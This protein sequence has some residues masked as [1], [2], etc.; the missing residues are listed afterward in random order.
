MLSLS[1]RITAARLP[2]IARST[3][4]NAGSRPLQQFAG[5]VNAWDLTVWVV[6]DQ[7]ADRV[8]HARF[9]PNGSSQSMTAIV[10]RL[11]ELGTVVDSLGY[12]TCQLHPIAELVW[13]LIDQRVPWK[14]VLVRHARHAMLPAAYD[15]DVRIGPVWKRG[16]VY[17]GGQPAP[18]SFKIT[19]D[20][21]RN[22]ISCPIE[23]EHTTDYVD[24]LRDEYRQWWHALEALRLECHANRDSLPGLAVRPLPYAAEP[25]SVDDGACKTKT[26]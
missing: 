17:H 6:R 23:P 10:A 9:T 7:R 25:W 22:A 11:L 19:Y 18:G 13:R 20:A 24:Q 26:T 2:P 21:N 16:P 4:A 5:G 12:E 1:K 3:T 14:G 8:D 15:L